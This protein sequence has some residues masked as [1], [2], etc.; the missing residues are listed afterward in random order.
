MNQYWQSLSRVFAE[1]QPREKVLISLCGLVV[2]ILALQTWLLDP[3][4]D[5][6]QQQ[7]SRL[8]TL[9]TNQ[10]TM[11]NT[12]QQLQS[13][14]S[15]NPDAEIDIELNHLQTHHQQLSQ[16]LSERMGG[17]VAP[18]Q[19]ASL[20]QEVLSKAQALTL[21]SLASL[22]AEPIR[23]TESG[24]AGDA[25]FIHPVRLEIIGSYFAIRD[26]LAA[27]E[28]LPVNYYWRRFHYQVDQ[29]PNGRLILEVYTLGTQK[30]FIGG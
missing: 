14:L 23:L 11:R 20:L 1:R 12:I 4:L 3:L 18:S 25:Y 19:M 6:Y 16:Q 28:S 17:L 15:S 30:E 10:H 22:P 13:Q 9:Q 21:V 24:V 2:I 8:Q 26:Y 27:L 29:H 7:S 5:R